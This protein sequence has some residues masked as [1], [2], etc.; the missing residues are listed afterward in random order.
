MDECAAVLVVAR[1]GTDDATG[2]ARLSM[3]IVDSDATGLDRTLIPVEIKA[4]EKQFQLFFDDVQVPCDRLLGEE[5]EGLRQVF[6]GLN[7]ERITGAAICTGLG[8]YALG[9]AAEYA[10]SARC[11]TCR[12]GA[13]KVWRTRSPSR[14][15]SWSWRA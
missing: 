8:R 12:S 1:T 11:G 10:A 9:R 2:D 15:S 14:R 7:P 4:P 3:F 6:S 13:T 5:H